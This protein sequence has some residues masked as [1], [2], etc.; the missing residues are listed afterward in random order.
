MYK[1]IKNSGGSAIA[2]GE[3]GMLMMRRSPIHAAEYPDDITL[4]C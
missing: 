2:Q 3:K 1:L 4:V